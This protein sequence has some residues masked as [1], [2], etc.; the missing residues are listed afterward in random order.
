MSRQELQ[1]RVL[2]FEFSDEEEDDSANRQHLIQLGPQDR[3]SNV[4]AKL[5]IRD[6]PAQQKRAPFQPMSNLVGSLQTAI[7]NYSLQVVPKN[8]SGTLNEVKV[9]G[10]PASACRCARRSSGTSH[11][12]LSDLPTSAWCRKCCPA[13]RWPGQRRAQH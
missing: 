13:R 10:R 4:N 1:R 3:T 9:T 8:T 2:R 11:R 12:G 7:S 5:A 6:P